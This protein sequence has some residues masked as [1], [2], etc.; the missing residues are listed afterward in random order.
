M[1]SR[2]WVEMVIQSCKIMSGFEE[3]RF[4]MNRTNKSVFGYYII[5]W[6]VKEPQPFTSQFIVL[7]KFVARVIRTIL[8]ARVITN[9]RTFVRHQ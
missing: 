7:G 1:H 5:C 8:I 2:N 6:S 3:F 4:K 9:N